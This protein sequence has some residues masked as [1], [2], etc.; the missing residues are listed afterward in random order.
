MWKDPEGWNRYVTTPI[1]GVE[2]L[3]VVLEPGIVPDA[4]T[5]KSVAI[6]RRLYGGAATMA[7]ALE[8]GWAA[9]G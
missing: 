8:N 2:P 4:V 3:H 7:E 1:D 6:V 5:A 9:T